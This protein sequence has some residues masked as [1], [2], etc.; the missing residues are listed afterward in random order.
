MPAL[1]IAG[2]Y[3][4]YG[5]GSIDGYRLLCENAGTEH[6]RANQYLV[7]GPWVHIPWGDQAGD[8]NFGPAACLDTDAVLLRWLNH[9]LMDTQE[10][11]EEPRA[12]VFVLGAN[13]WDAAPSIPP[14]DPAA[15]RSTRFFLRSGGAAN[16]RQGDGT[17]R[18]GAS[19]VR[20]R[21]AGPFHLRSRGARPRARRAGCAQRPLRPGPA[22]SGQQRAG[23]HLR[24]ALAETL[25]VCGEP[26]LRMYAATSC[27]PTDFCGKLVRVDPGG[28]ARFICLGYARSTALF[29]PGEHRRGR[30]LRLGFHAGC[31]CVRVRRRR[32]GAAGNRQ[33][34]LS[35]C[36]S[37]IRTPDSVPAARATAFDWRRS[38]QIVFH[39]A[40][41]ASL[42]TL[43]LASPASPHPYDADRAHAKSRRSRA[44]RI[45]ARRRRGA[46]PARTHLT[47]KGVGKTYRNG[48]DVLQGIDLN[49]D[50]GSF[51]SI[52]GPSGCGKSTLLKLVSGLSSHLGRQD[53]HRGNDPGQRAG[54]HVVYLSGR[55]APAV[56]QRAA[57]RRPRVGT[58]GHFRRAARGKG[59]RPACRRG[60]GQRGRPLSAAAFRRDEDA[61]FHRPRPC[62]H[63]AGCC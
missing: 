12:R 23:V 30:R 57:Q 46:V 62:H 61:R 3:D 20:R 25:L 42:L 60:V 26:R 14:S 35:A 19:R 5:Q 63:A 52:I 49:I 8:D 58:G 29:P 51:V 56:A 31:H 22:G 16:S 21:A 43:P 10:W 39:D 38:T 9:W 18:F 6:A 15:A 54:N 45:R 40:G 41:R 32:P 2:W 44:A 36:S 47:L 53:R 17:P 48:A 4:T 33:Q 34:R 27:A 13:R 11:A 7:A 59:A 37:A 55:H 1:H 24:A 50:A 28:R